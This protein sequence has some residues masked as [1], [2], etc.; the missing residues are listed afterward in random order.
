MISSRQLIFNDREINTEFF[1]RRWLQIYF[2]NA[3]IEGCK[4][5][6][7]E[8]WKIREN[9]IPY[10]MPPFARSLEEIC[11]M[12]SQSKDNICCDKK[13]PLNIELDY[14]WSSTGFWGIR[15]MQTQGTL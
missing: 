11:K 14:M 1:F 12:S 7:A 2:V 13:P 5:H 9:Y 8:K 6:K 4:V 15:C 3:G 10:N